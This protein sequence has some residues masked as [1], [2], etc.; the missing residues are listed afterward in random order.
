MARAQVLAISSGLYGLGGVTSSNS[1]SAIRPEGIASVSAPVEED[2]IRLESYL[3]DE[4]SAFEPEVRPL[5][6]YTLKHSGK[7]IRP[8]L[9]FFGGWKGQAASAELIRAAA[10][11]EL[12]HLATLVHD[13]ILDDAEMRHRTPTLTAKHGADVAVLLG[14]ALFAHALRLAS[15]FPTVDVCRAVSEATRQVCSGEIAQ[16]FSRGNA[17]ITLQ[18]YY[19]MIDLKTAELFSVAAYLG[20][21]LGHG[22]GAYADA[23]SKFARSLGVAYQIFDD[24]ADF[25]SLEERAGKTLGTDLKSGKFTLPVLVFLQSLPESESRSW[26]QRLTEGETSMEELKGS[27]LKAGAFRESRRLFFEEIERGEAILSAYVDQ[28]AV[29]LFLRLSGFI[30]AAFE[31]FAI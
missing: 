23:I 27:M 16:T 21:F 13:D 22:N 24:I 19:R 17:E 28:P 5:V 4:V 6:A 1:A 26:R 11:V 20:A 2:L 30:R 7:K 9:V 29:P 15:D 25:L 12:V 14:D 3:Q 31:R 10:V 18:A 8:I